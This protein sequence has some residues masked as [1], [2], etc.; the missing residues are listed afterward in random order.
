VSKVD[1]LAKEKEGHSLDPVVDVDHVSDTAGEGES[2]EVNP[3]QV[4]KSQRD[5]VE[6]ERETSDGRESDVQRS[7]DFHEDY[8]FN[9][10]IFQ[11]NPESRGLH[12]EDPDFEDV[13][14]LVEETHYELEVVE[15]RERGEHSQSDQ[16]VVSPPFTWLPDN[17]LKEYKEV[18]RE[19]KKNRGGQRL[20]ELLVDNV[21]EDQFELV[22]QRRRRRTE[23]RRRSP[24][25]CCRDMRRKSQRSISW[26]RGK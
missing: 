19:S 26:S 1:G 18:E 23:R 16:V 3:N 2:L 10:F 12:S 4:D 7:T 22:S 13:S 20:P 15:E 17:D 21:A 14:Q 6:I 5:R 25:A 11:L 9:L 24:G 8:K